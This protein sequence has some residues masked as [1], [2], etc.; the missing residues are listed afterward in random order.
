MIRSKVTKSRIIIPV[1]IIVVFVILFNPFDNL[2]DSP[3]EQI[4]QSDNFDDLIQLSADDIF[5]SNKIFLEMEEL[6]S[7]SIIN[8][9]VVFTESNDSLVTRFLDEQQID[10]PF[11]TEKFGIETQVALFDST[12]TVYHTSDVLGISQ[13]SVTDSDGKLLDLGS[14][15]V[16]FES[17]SK[18]KETATNVWGV[19]EFY[20]DDDKVD[21][22][23][24]W[25]SGTN[26][27]RLT[28]SL[29]D[30][31]TFQS[32]RE[33]ENLKSELQSLES[34]LLVMRSKSPTPQIEIVLLEE[35]VTVRDKISK[36]SDMKVPYPPSFSNQEKKNHTFT[37]SDEGREWKHD[38]EHTYRIVLTEVH[39]N[40]SSNQDHKEFHWKGQ[41][42]AYE[43]K[44][45]VDEHKKVILD[46]NNEAISI[47]KS[48]I[49]L[50]V[51]GN[52]I[53]QW[54]QYTHFA[55][56]IAVQTVSPFPVTITDID[57]A[58]IV[59]ASIDQPDAPKPI[60]EGTTKAKRAWYGTNNI[61]NCSDVISGIPRDADVIFNINGEQITVHTPLSQINYYET[62]K[63]YDPTKTKHCKPI[64]RFSHLYPDCPNGF[65]EWS[66]PDV[67]YKSNFGYN[68]IMSRGN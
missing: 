41:H 2:D 18:Q 12:N 4:Q 40:F 21:S 68:K 48:D 7:S 66:Y 58:I 57:G 61:V 44:V 27:D 29:L 31:L 63:F 50:Q 5:I 13:L 45:I 54:N 34:E 20:L 36:F 3:L 60:K 65:L 59:T 35:I 8:T 47:F 6:K 42:I 33:K 26:S 39:A 30:T 43:L 53:F 16:S 25:A 17:I 51:C 1:L 38:S 55:K 49:T 23:Y 10:S 14:I 9:D 11:S 24:L 37:L 46:E 62:V 32:N 64:D 19:V 22:K 15:Q 67:E 52:S 56:H 28:L